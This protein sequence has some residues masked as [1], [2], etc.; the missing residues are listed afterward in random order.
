MAA[1]AGLAL[2]YFRSAGL[3]HLPVVVPGLVDVA[4]LVAWRETTTLP[5]DFRRAVPTILPGAALLTAYLVTQV[6]HLRPVARAI[7][8]LPVALAGLLLTTVMPML[9]TPPM[10]G[11]H[12]QIAEL[13]NQLPESAVV[14][15]D[16]R[17]PGHMALA[18]QHSFNR[19]SFR[20]EA[21]P[22]GDVG[23]S[24]FFHRFLD[25]GY[26]VFV[27]MAPMVGDQAAMLKRSDLAEF[28]IRPMRLVTLQYDLIAP[29][30]RRFPRD[31]RTDTVPVA[32]YQ[33]REVDPAGAALPLVLD[34]GRSD[35]HAV[36]EGFHMPELFQS[37]EAR[38]TASEARIALPRLAPMPQRNV[39]LLLRFSADR[40]AGVPAP[41]I[42][43]AI[44]D[45]PA[46]RLESAGPDF[47]E[48]RVVLPPAAL[49]R[50]LAGPSVLSVST[51][52][53]TPKDVGLNE[54]ARQLGVVLDWVRIE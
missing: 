54:D 4:L 22:P 41:T 14:V 2:L 29:V 27:A 25:A 7:W 10:Q 38:W 53:F 26:P 35:L 1:L 21:R 15:I 40:P 39:T 8:L 6:A 11:V 12:A 37:T 13:A 17:I 20:L 52:S 28:D 24:S 3:R 51:D 34:I 16:R 23:L 19:S 5:E 43:L 30:R 18:L 50:L 32:L 42:Q 46:G 48:Y 44:D 9:R 45:L 33:I 36:L 47:L 31:L 49:A